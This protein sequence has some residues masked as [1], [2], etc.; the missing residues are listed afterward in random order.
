[1]GKKK[2]F[3]DKQKLK[4]YMNTKPPLQKILKEILH[5]GNENKHKYERM[6]IIKPQ[7]K[8]RQVIRISCMHTNPTQQKQLNGINH[9]IPLNISTQ[10]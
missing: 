5:T 3:H 6:G 1:L 4:Q 10:Y 8:S 9:H 2:I 7:E